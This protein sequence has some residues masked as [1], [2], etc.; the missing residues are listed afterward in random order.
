MKM[1]TQF[2]EVTYED[3]IK[4]AEAQLKGKP[5]DKL[6][7]KTYEGITIK[8]LY[9]AKDV[10]NS[11]PLP[12]QVPFVRGTNEEDSS[13]LVNQFISG[14]DFEKL[15][16][17][18]KKALNRGQNS[19]YFS[20]DPVYHIDH[21]ST[22][23]KDIHIEEVHLYIDATRNRVF[24]PLFI[25]YCEKQQISTSKLNGTIAI[26]PFYEMV[27][28]GEDEKAFQKASDFLLSSIKWSIQN[29]IHLN[30]ALLNSKEFHEA[31]SNI[32]QELAF[33]FLK[34]IELLETLTDQGISVEDITKR[35]QFSFQIGS[36][37]FMEIA[38]LRAAKIV[39]ATIVQAYGGKE[40]A[41]K[42]SIHAETSTLNKSKLDSHVNLLRTTG[43]AFA[44][45]LGGVD[46]LTITPFDEVNQSSELAERI[47]RNTH[48]IMQ[49]ESLLNKI[50]DPAGGSYYIDSLTNSLAEKVWEMI[51]SYEKDGG[52]IK[53]LKEGKV[54]KEIEEIYLLKK[55][56]IEY[57]K[58]ILIGTNVYANLGEELIIS[59]H[60]KDFKPLYFTNFKDFEAS[61]D[62]IEQ[63]GGNALSLR[64]EL[65]L[66]DNAKVAPLIRNRLSEPFETLR[67]NAENFKKLNG[68]YPTLTI[69]TIGQLKHYKPRLDFVKG[70]LATG[71]MDVKVLSAQDHEDIDDQMIILC[72]RDEDYD[73]LDNTFID[74]LKNKAKHLWIVASPDNK[75][76]DKWRIE[77]TVH[78]KLNA[79]EWLQDVQQLLGVR[80]G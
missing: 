62:R 24:L 64:E 44:A 13:W 3:W 71:G 72:G 46:S 4:A 65:T 66:L 34:A 10:E 28:L 26:D 61:L 20:V 9:E 43:E 39:W 67:F 30:L 73:Q 25:H 45:V 48:F 31:G 32:V 36:D 8:P 51:Q 78:A 47:A 38:K 41:Q 23:L 12:G 15:N 42:I 69:V 60:K 18:L 5:F 6:F 16:E 52:F 1:G 59:E 80:E 40:D 56:D 77:K 17:N 68:Y 54:Q 63:N 7:S 21:L 49:E 35:I 58:R 79:Y 55:K 53:A 50:Q 33:T 57:K 14:E 29:D 76:A 75:Y 2:Q 19:L 37:F 22:I 70:L 27:R 11:F 74:S